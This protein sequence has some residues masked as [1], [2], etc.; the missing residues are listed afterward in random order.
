MGQLFDSDADD[1]SISIAMQ[2][3]KM[4]TPDAIQEEL[5]NECA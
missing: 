1:G 4:T 3:R 2:H 5:G